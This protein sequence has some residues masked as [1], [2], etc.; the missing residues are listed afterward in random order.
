LF[1]FNGNPSADGLPLKTNN[2]KHMNNAG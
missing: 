2:Y 1:V